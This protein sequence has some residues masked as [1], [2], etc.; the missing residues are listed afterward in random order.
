MTYPT[1]IFLFSMPRSGSTLLQ[2]IMAAHEAIATTTE[3]WVLLGPLYTLKAKG[4]IAEYNHA[5][6]CT[7]V[8]DFCGTLPGGRDDYLAEVRDFVLRLYARAAPDGTTYFL[9]KT[10]RYLLVISEI[11]LL[12]KTKE[13]V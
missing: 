11:I 7:A 5:S 1:P 8:T 9:D 4:V 10:P 6:L 3:P 13:Q 2:R 12:E